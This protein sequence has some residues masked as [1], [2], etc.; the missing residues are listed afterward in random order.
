M[1]ARDRPADA[2]TPRQTGHGDRHPRRP[3]QAIDRFCLHR[4]HANSAAI[5]ASLQTHGHPFDCPEESPLFRL[6]DSIMLRVMAEHPDQIE[7][8]FAT[9]FGRNPVNRIFRFLDKERLGRPKWS[10]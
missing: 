8:T 9:M 3:A 2:A 7:P 6:L 5:V 1:P 10:S 4:V